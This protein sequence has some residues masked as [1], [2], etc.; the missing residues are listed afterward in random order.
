M[1]TVIGRLPVFLNTRRTPA[2]V[3]RL[4]GAG[5]PHTRF[6]SAGAGAAASLLLAD[7]PSRG[8]AGGSVYEALVAGAAA[9]HGLGLVTRDRRALEIYRAFEVCVELLA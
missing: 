2:A 6:L 4:L 7:L 1:A 3:A 9:E 8:I 5:F